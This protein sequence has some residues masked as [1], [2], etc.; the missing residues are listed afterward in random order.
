[1]TQ[2]IAFPQCLMNDRQLARKLI[3]VLLIKLVLI[4]G[5]WWVFI[6][7]QKVEVDSAAMAGA[8]GTHQTTQ[9]EATG[10]TRHGH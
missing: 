8:L 3:A 7:G 4:V 6:R 1:M 5:L 10:E 9:T 2:T